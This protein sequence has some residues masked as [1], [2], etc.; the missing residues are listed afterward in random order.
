MKF[1]Y[2]PFVNSNEYDCALLLNSME[3]VF[4]YHEMS[5]ITDYAVL[6]SRSLEYYGKIELH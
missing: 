3:V 5:G 4:S 2:S 1:V 6:D